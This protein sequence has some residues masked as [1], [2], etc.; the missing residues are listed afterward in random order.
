MRMTIAENINNSLLSSEDDKIFLKNVEEGFQSTCKS[1]A[2]TLMS[3][4]I[5]MKYDGAK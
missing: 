4:L 5:T 3:R 2:G 1:L